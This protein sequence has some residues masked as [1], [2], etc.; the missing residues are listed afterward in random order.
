MAE[1]LPGNS[2]DEEPLSK[3]FDEGMKLYMK[4]EDEKEPI[5]SE[6]VQLT[7]KQAISK[8]EKATNLVSVS[9]MFSTNESLEELPTETLQY[10]LLPVLLGKLTLKLCA[11][12]LARVEIINVAE[13]YFRDFLQRCKDY[14]VTDVEI[15][16]PTCADPKAPCKPLTEQAKI[17]NMVNSREVKIKRYKEMKEI[18]EK[19]E[20]LRYAM[21]S[22]N[23]D[24]ET[25][26]E[27]FTTLLTSHVNESLDEL[28][29]IEQEKPILEYMSKHAGELKQPKRPAP[30]K[31]VII[32]RDAVQKAVYG[33]GYPALPTLTIE[34]FYDQRVR[35]GTFP[36][37]CKIPHATIQAADDDP[38]EAEKIR[39]EQL[40]ETEDP[41]E[42][43]R[44]RNM[45]EFKDDHRRG[46]GNRHNRS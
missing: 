12:G 35:E 41:E 6:A 18:K 15:P 13:I 14:G 11:Q 29:S 3:L 27:Y 24:D 26:R 37:A 1:N 9:G 23:V 40:V 31:P 4:L 39:K 46:W 7:I 36:G 45:D 20:K 28:N 2:K 44:Q 10:L 43:A 38:D 21:T 30:L 42:I 17:A 25:R 32:T 16:E 33:L 5:S 8:F 34:E 19:L 22:I